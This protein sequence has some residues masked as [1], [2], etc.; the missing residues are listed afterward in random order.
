[1]TWLSYEVMSSLPDGLA[2]AAVAECHWFLVS[3]GWRTDNP[4]GYLRVTWWINT[5]SQKVMMLW[6]V[7]DDGSHVAMMSWR[8]MFSIIISQI[9]LSRGPRICGSV[10]AGYGRVPSRIAYRLH[11]SVAFCMSRWLCRQQLSYLSVVVWQ[12][13]GVPSLWE[14]FGVQFL[15][16]HWERGHLVWLWRLRTWRG[17]KSWQG[18]RLGH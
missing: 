4:P 15:L 3:Y 14:L 18:S 16:W 8:V 6:I 7:E 11:R 10:P 2:A 12:A 5:P 1:M 17:A 13:T 9:V